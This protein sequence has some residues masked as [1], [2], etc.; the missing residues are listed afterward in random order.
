MW[1][2]CICNCRRGCAYRTAPLL[3]PPT[4][5]QEKEGGGR[6]NEDLR[7]RLAVK[8][9]PPLPRIRVVCSAVEDENSF[10]R[11][12]MA[13][14]KDGRVVGHV[15]VQSRSQTPPTGRDGRMTASGNRPRSAKKAKTSSQAIFYTL[16]TTL[17][18]LQHACTCR[19]ANWL[20]R[21]AGGGGGRVMEVK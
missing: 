21:P 6:N 9:P 5:F 18:R 10:D 19:T 2:V 7:F 13:I 1:V 3:R 15:H 4:Y 8:P 16:D 17:L 11:H 14:L 12:A 20:E